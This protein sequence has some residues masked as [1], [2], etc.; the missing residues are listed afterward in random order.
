MPATA[1][2]A[3]IVRL[4]NGDA[5]GA[6]I[7]LNAATAFHLDTTQLAAGG[8]FRVFGRN[9][10]L[11]GYTPVVKVDGWAAA[12]DGAASDENMLVATAPLR[13]GN[14]ARIAVSVDNG[15]GTGASLME[16]PIASASGDGKDPFGLGVG[17]A[18]AF[19]GIASRVLLAA[20]DQRLQRPVKCNGSQDDSKGLQ[21]AIDLANATGG[22]TVWLPEG[23][24]RLSATVQLKSNVVV[25]GAGP[26]RT[27]LAYDANYPLL[28]RGVSLAGLR[29]FSL[30]NVAGTIES[31]LLQKSDR[32]FFSNV[33][34][35]INGGIQM[36]LTENLNVVIDHCEFL[37]PKN[38]RESGPFVLSG[39][40]GLVFTHNRVV[41]A[42]GNPNFGGVHDAY[43]GDNHIS[44]DVRDNQHSK[45]VVHSLTLDFAH[46]VAVVNN[47]LDVLGGPIVNKRRNDGETIL[48]EGGGGNRTENIGYVKAATALTLTD[49]DV[50]HKVRPF[51]AGEIPENYAVAIVA[52]TGTGQTRRVVG[53]N[54]STLTVDHAWDIVPDAS[55]HYA[56]FVWGLEK[57]L[58]KGN[59]LSQNAR[60]I[61]LYQTAVKDVDIVSNTITEGGGIYLRTA[62][63]LKDR[64]F[65]PMY[66]VK[67][68]NNT[69]F[70]SSSEWPS[71]IHLAFVRMDE[72][73][74]GLGAIGVE[75][76]ANTLQANRPNVSLNEEESGGVEGFVVRA[77]FEGESQGRSKNQTRLLGTIFQDN[78]CTDCNVGLLVRE[79]AQGTV[80]DGNANS[81]TDLQKP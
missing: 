6:P 9:L 49:P 17:W 65:T 35:E 38:P 46:R 2:G 15:N 56:T 76:R 68:A 11:P 59:T 74:F 10:L 73:A 13:L 57:T 80:L 19:S 79:G 3:L 61:W 22:G 4:G 40:A 60:G 34:F 53:Y 28:G 62:Q 31:A 58:I 21:E 78:Q 43:V 20:S 5:L 8:K 54:N 24:C 23:T 69:I 29:N 77:R 1:S 39:S 36:F 66:G 33:V 41:F 48:T 71:Y 26:R 44:R 16:R 47:V 72:P 81:V 27:V 64:L 25:Q 75:I 18:S 45:G 7:K 14:K 52:G 50:V 51:G 12:I 30:R 67:V 42:N 63:S 37:Q 32:V 55:S 70:N